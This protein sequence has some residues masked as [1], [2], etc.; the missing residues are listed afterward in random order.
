MLAII[1]W[2]QTDFGKDHHFN[3]IKTHADFAKNKS[4]YAI[5]KT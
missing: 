1:Q 4:L 5:T 2:R 3:A